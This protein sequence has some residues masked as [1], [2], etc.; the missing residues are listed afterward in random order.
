MGN[1]PTLNVAYAAAM[2]TVFDKYPGDIDLHALYA[3]SLMVLKPWKLWNKT[4]TDAGE[5]EITAAD[6]NTLE[7]VRVIEAGFELEGGKQSP[8]LC[9]LYC[10]IMELSP[11]PEKALPAADTLRTLMPDCGHLVHMPSH[12]DAWVGQWKEGIDANKAGVA[13][14]DKFCKQAD[15]DSMFY[16]FYRMHNHHFVVW[17]A[18]HDGQYTTAMEYSRKAEAQLPAGDKDSGVNFLLAGIIPMGKVFLESYCTMVW[19]TMVRFGKWDEILAEPTRDDKEVYAGTIATQHYAR[20]VAYASTGRV[21]EAE[22]E[23]KLFKEA[24]TNP[25]LA[26]RVLH[27]NPMYQDPATGPSLL[28][29]SDAILDGEIAYRRQFLAKKEG[30]A[31]DFTAA[32]DHLRRGVTLSLNLAYNEPWGQMQPVR[33]ILGALL[34]EQGEV[35]EAEAVYRADIKLWKNNMWGLLGLKNCLVKKKEDSKYEVSE[36]EVAEVSALFAER[37]CRADVVPT[38]TCFCAQAQEKKCCEAK[39]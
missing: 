24:L 10:H 9:H 13:A 32:F 8:T 29:V 25:N 37:S 31:A 38:V 19:H 34:L 15:M 14:D 16:K 23:Q 18:M 30:G 6:D 12:I 26:G 39:E 36:G 27:N 17:C 33:H 1:D 5:I 7:A 3:E 4:V 11:T 2:K 20:G 22:A 35:E 21:A 28:C